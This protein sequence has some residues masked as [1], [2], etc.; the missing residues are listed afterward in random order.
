MV[1]WQEVAGAIQ[2]G[3]GALVM[4]YFFVRHVLAENKAKTETIRL[5]TLKNN[6]AIAAL[7][8]S[9]HFLEVHSKEIRDLGT[10]VRKDLDLVLIK[11]QNL[12]DEISGP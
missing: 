3:L 12:R 8:L 5:L 1:G 4:G 7:S 6:E 9:N 2:G 11:I 10:G